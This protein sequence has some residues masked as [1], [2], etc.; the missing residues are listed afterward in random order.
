MKKASIIFYWVIFLN[1]SYSQ[2]YLLDKKSFVNTESDTEIGV[3]SV[4]NRKE[5][6][7]DFAQMLVNALQAK[8]YRA[9]AAIF[10]TDFVKKGLFDKIFAGDFIQLKYQDFD[11]VIDFLC[12]S[13]VESKRELEKNAYEMQV[14]EV[15]VNFKI[16]S[17]KKGDI[18]DSF[19]LTEKGAGFSLEQAEKTAINQIVSNFKAKTLNLSL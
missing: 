9:T 5:M 10:S 7:R 12:L 6:D 2:T 4:N 13:K 8:E 16:L 14:V 3:I 17:A 1:F 11:E 19:S 18:V 15:T